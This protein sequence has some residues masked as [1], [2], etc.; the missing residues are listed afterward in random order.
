MWNLQRDDAFGDDTVSI[1]RRGA[2]HSPRELLRPLR[3]RAYPVVMPLAPEYFTADMVRALPDDGTRRE[4]V[5]GELLVTPAPRGTHQRIAFRLARLLAD[6]CDALGTLETLPSPAD[7]SWGSDTLVQPD[8]FVVPKSEAITG[9]WTR[10]RSLVLVAE[11]LSPS[12]ARFDRFQKRKLYQQQ[13]VSTLWLVDV[14]RRLVDV[15]TPDARFPVVE[16]ARVS[17]HPAGATEP[18]VIEIAAL[19]RET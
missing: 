17:W 13:R 15:W 5:W 3:R 16:T 18:L 14:D 9:D 19:L 7:I 11:I 10:M 1:S 6:Y 8:V 4:L 2:V 12:T